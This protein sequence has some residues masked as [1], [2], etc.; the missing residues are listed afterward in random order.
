MTDDVILVHIITGFLGSGKTTLLNRLLA[1]PGLLDT[2][3]IINEFG[4]IGLD[5][6]LV[7]GAIDNV[8][9]M[10][11]GCL[12]C[13]ASGSLRETL[14]DLYVRRGSGDLP[15]FRR[16]LIETSGLA[17]PG[18][19]ILTLARDALL[20]DRFKLRGVICV[21]D[22]TDDTVLNCFPEA[23]AQAVMADRFVITK[24][25]RAGPERVSA[26][27]TAL[28]TLN[29]NAPVVMG[30]AI[31]TTPEALLST[32]YALGWPAET[33]GHAHAHA[34]GIAS[35]SLSD[36]RAVTWPHLARW[37]AELRADWGDD[38]LRLK[39]LLPLVA[40][41]RPVL[42]QGVRG[43]FDVQQLDAWPDAFRHG[44]IV[45]IGIGIDRAAIEAGCRSLYTDDG[46]R[47]GRSGAAW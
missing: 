21:A 29:A 33:D 12:C 32:D 37:T 46:A 20:K 23:R 31:A 47:H 6:L 10:D 42:V 45:A 24:L 9:L 43:A 27:V 34:S 2:A 36:P 3:V 15:P 19:I 44:R 17:D 14:I 39:A 38:L 26:L 4:E 22:A 28:R 11:G 16:V 5:H 8:L 40:Q 35:V 18:P 1:N 30:D 41:H 7:E 25:D 13:V